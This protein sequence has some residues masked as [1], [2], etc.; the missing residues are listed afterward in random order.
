MFSSMGSSEREREQRIAAEAE[1]EIVRALAE[2][3]ELREIA[4][5]IARR[6]ELDEIKAYRWS[7]YIDQ[8][9]QKRRKRIALI[10]L[11][12]MWAGAIAL[13]VGVV[14]LLFIATT[15]VWAVVTGIGALVALPALIVALLAR[16][17][18]YRRSRGG[19]TF[20]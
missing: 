1:P 2:G 16:R 17:I 6:Y 3:R 20:K 18:A 11:S 10:A 8:R 13:M 5:E 14:A 12:I 15:V 19:T 7:S 4:E 9:Y